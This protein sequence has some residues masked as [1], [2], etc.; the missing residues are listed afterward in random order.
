[1]CVVGADSEASRSKPDVTPEE[2]LSASNIAEKLQNE[3]AIFVTV[4]IVIV[5]LLLESTAK[6][7]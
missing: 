5:E 3:F 7:I 2:S 4:N 6:V 1:V